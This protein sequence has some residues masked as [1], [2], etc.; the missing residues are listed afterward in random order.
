[1]SRRVTED[2]LADRAWDM[3]LAAW[4]NCTVPDCHFKQCTWTGT[5]LCFP[6]ACDKLGRRVV[7]GLFK[8]THP[9]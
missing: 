6:H 9:K 7:E 3:I 8:A 1:M 5:T 2:E 4:P